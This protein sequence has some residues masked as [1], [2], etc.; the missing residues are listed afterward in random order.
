MVRRHAFVLMLIA[1]FGASASNAFAQTVNAM[2][3]AVIGKVTDDSDAILP[4]VSVTLKGPSLKGAK[5]DVT[6]GEGLYRLTAVPPGIYVV[7]FELQG[8]ATVHRADLVI[9]AGFTATVNMKLG[10]ATLKESV[11]VTGQSPVV[12][13]AA[14]NISTRFDANHLATLPGARDYWAILSEAPSVKMQ[15]I[16]VG[17][18]AAGTQTTYVVYG[19]T[20]QNRPMIEGINSTEGTDAFGNYVDMG[21]FEY[22]TP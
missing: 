16:D 17:G 18:S 21:S 13:T 8:F 20:G 14:T 19:T 22:Q 4:G 1:L 5:A 10:V 15:R 12:D 7:D 9:G 6:D 11:T 3:G 2:T